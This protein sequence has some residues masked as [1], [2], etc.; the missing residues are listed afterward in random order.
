MKVQVLIAALNQ[1]KDIVKKLN[2][3]TDAILSNQCD[4]NK[5]EEFKYEKNNI[6]C[7]NFISSIL[8]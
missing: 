5:V 1:E 4:E 8:S 7:L 2:I 3:Q 6:L